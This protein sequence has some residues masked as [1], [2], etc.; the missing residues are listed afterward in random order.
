MLY[1][2]CHLNALIIAQEGSFRYAIH[3][4]AS[5]H[6]SRRLE[7][8]QN[9]HLTA[10][11]KWQK[12]SSHRLVKGISKRSIEKISIWPKSRQLAGLREPQKTALFRAFS[13]LPLC[14]QCHALNVAR[15]KEQ[16]FH[17][18]LHPLPGLYGRISRLILSPLTSSAS[19]WLS[20]KKVMLRMV[21]S[22]SSSSGTNCSIPESALLI[23]SLRS[24]SVTTLPTISF[25]F[26]TTSGLRSR[27][28]SINS[29]TSTL[30]ASS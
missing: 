17:S 21:S 23:S 30:R 8:R 25:I 12:H 3:L 10:S 15:T 5:Q 7:K 2:R 18:P 28:S 27:T 16:I 26:F 24:V 22:K 6:P 20:G 1:Q 14:H 9:I 11:Q 29:F 19:I 4:A 13:A